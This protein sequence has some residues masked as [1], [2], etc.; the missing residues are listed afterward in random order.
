MCTC[1]HVSIGHERD[2]GSLQGLSS[3]VFLSQDSLWV[4]L[5]TNHLV[6]L[7]N[8]MINVFP[9]FSL[10]FITIGWHKN[11]LNFYECQVEWHFCVCLVPIL[12]SFCEALCAHTHTYH[13]LA[14]KHQSKFISQ[15]LL[16]LCWLTVLSFLSCLVFLLRDQ[17]TPVLSEMHCKH[18]PPSQGAQGSCTA[19]TDQVTLTTKLTLALQPGHVSQVLM[20][21]SANSFSEVVHRGIW[22]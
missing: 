12:E 7:W 20:R 6:L 18:L 9:I 10:P 14:Q 16:S 1:A 21:E 8:W 13:W 2:N 5:W 3:S 11:V 4:W 15:A 19:R 22:L 17:R